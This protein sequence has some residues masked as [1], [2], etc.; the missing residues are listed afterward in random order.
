MTRVGAF[1][2]TL[3]YRCEVIVVDDGSRPDGREAAERAMICCPTAS[4]ARC[5][6]HEHNRGKGAA[7]RT[8]CLAASGQRIAFIDADLATPPEDLPGL[9]GALDA[10][11][12]IAIGVRTQGDGSDMRDRRGLARRAAGRSVYIR[13]AHRAVAGYGRQPVPSQSISSLGGETGVSAST[14]RDVGFRRGAAISGLE[15][16]TEGGEGASGL[17]SR[18]WLSP[19]A[20]PEQRPRAMESA[21]N[22]VG[23]SRRLGYDAARGDCASEITSV[24]SGGGIEGNV[25]NRHPWSSILAALTKTS[26][27]NGAGDRSAAR[28]G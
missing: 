16:G 19:A 5:C 2:L 10:G 12:D 15:A 13:H 20:Q 25:S 24:V 4:S 1:L 8:G 9:L 17:E 7:V 11:A 14:R 23:T 3:G 6:V 22:T 18:R 28:R 21:S 27:A 26:L